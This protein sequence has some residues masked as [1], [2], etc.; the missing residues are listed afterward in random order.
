MHLNPGNAYLFVPNISPI[1]THL[2]DFLAG[3][4]VD[5]WIVSL[6]NGE[7]ALVFLAV[8]STLA[9]IAA[10]SLFVFRNELRQDDTSIPRGIKRIA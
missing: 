2:G 4:Y 6:L 1:P 3:R 7:G 9:G 10:G 8:L 5:L